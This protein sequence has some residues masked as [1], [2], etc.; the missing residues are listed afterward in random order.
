MNALKIGPLTALIMGLC[1]LPLNGV[2]GIQ[3]AR[4][5]NTYW[6]LILGGTPEENEVSGQLANLLVE[7]YGYNHENIV[8]VTGDEATRA[9][10]YEALTAIDNQLMPYD[11]IF[12]YLSTSVWRY[13][14]SVLFKMMDSNGNEPWSWLELSLIVDWLKVLPVSAGLVAYPSCMNSG[15]NRLDSFTLEQLDYEIN[16]PGSIET[17]HVCDFESRS[18]SNE[19]LADT[20]LLESR[21]RFSQDLIEVLGEFA[22]T[23]EQ[24]LSSRELAARLSNQVREIAVIR[25]PETY[26]NEFTF[27]PTPTEVTKFV[28]RYKTSDQN[29]RQ[30]ALTSMIATASKESELAP[31]TIIFLKELAISP[32]ALL[33]PMESDSINSA[34]KYRLQAVQGLYQ[35]SENVQAI[36]ALGE[37]AI[38]AGEPPMVRKSA[39]GQLA[40]LKGRARSQEDV[41]RQ[42]LSDPDSSVRE[43]AVRAILL[44]QTRA[45]LPELLQMASD[46]SEDGGVRVSAL[47]AVSALGSEANIDDVMG[48]LGENSA[49]IRREAA[50]TLGRLG[51]S[52]SATEALLRVLFDEN[53]TVQSAAVNSIAR[54]YTPDQRREVVNEL[55]RILIRGDDSVAVAAAST[56]GNIGELSAEPNLRRV[57]QNKRNSIELRIAAAEA[58]GQLKSQ[59]SVKALIDASRSE[60]PGLRGAAVTALGRIKGEDAISALLERLDDEDLYVR[61]AAQEALIGFKPSVEGLIDTLAHESPQVRMA[62][63]SKAEE[64]PNKNFVGPLISK[65]NDSDSAVREASIRTLMAYQD[66][67]IIEEVSVAMTSPDPSTRG[68]SALIL[69]GIEHPDALNALII[70]MQDRDAGVRTSA[71]QAIAQAT[72]APDTSVPAMLEATHDPDVSV[73]QSAV[74]GLTAWTGRADVNLRLREISTGNDADFIRESA[75]RALF[76][77]GI[78]I[79]SRIMNSNNRQFKQYRKPDERE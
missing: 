10:I 19:G 79:D 17:F 13:E 75:S 60:T 40:L 44:T 61:T 68:G 32:T 16:R 23:N 76:E 72:Y 78:D 2:A 3:A 54:T 9:N 73:R 77:E 53:P 41:L 1:L 50:L 56:L 65:L 14:N 22:A 8:V 33:D 67:W 45:A 27:I 24:P 52:A 63:I 51:K 70:G 71:V 5:S 55:K 12:V 30:S 11:S 26:P 21:T 36:E 20:Q 4:E 46:G 34:L 37:I 66:D 62:A 57:L 49:S 28:E 38:H 59:R 15:E 25:H 39:I 7:K 31:P 74:E 29:Y 64:Y 6:A 42:T 69:G 35:F 58:M 18:Y 43:E 48:L 47:K